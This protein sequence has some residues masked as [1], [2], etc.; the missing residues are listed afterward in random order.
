MK[1]RRYVLMMVLSAWTAAVCWAEPES[2]HLAMVSNHAGSTGRRSLL[3]VPNAAAFVKLARED[4]VGLLEQLRATYDQN[5]QDYTMTLVKRERLAG[6]LSGSQVIDCR[7]RSEPFSVYLEWKQGAD[8]AERILYVPGRL[9]PKMLARPR[10]AASWFVKTAKVD[11][12]PRRAKEASLQTI[13]GF[14]W[15][16]SLDSLIEKTSSARKRGE[17]VE[18]FL[19]DAEYDGTETLAVEFRFPKRPEYGYGRIKMHFSRE[20]LLPVAT[21]IWDWEDRM[22][23]EYSFLD[24]KVNVGLEDSDFEP[25]VCGLQ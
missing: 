19:D 3:R 16:K 22:L 23:A 9:G 18:A 5:I 7:F 2:V 8:K 25:K 12:K 20:T 1:T 10:G 17:L 15:I 13:D 6:K 21:F 11:P 4:Q 14:G 24:V